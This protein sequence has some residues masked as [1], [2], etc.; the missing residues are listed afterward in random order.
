MAIRAHSLIVSLLK[1]QAQLRFDNCIVGQIL[2]FF[3]TF[4]SIRSW[5]IILSYNNNAELVSEGNVWKVQF[6]NVRLPESKLPYQCI[7]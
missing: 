5:G 6:Q 2:S 4:M 1:L 3:G 7:F